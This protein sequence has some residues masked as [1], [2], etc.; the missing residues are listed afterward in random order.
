MT[1]YQSALTTLIGEVLADPELAHQDVFRRM[2]QAGLQ[3]LVNANTVELDDSYGVDSGC[4]GLWPVAVLFTFD[5]P[6]GVFAFDDAG[7]GSR[8]S[9][10][11]QSAGQ[12]GDRVLPE[13]GEDGVAVRVRRGERRPV[14]RSSGVRPAGLR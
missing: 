3:D 1:Q 11:E 8:S 6:A 10:R 12:L 9:L 7:V 2:L 5:V 13:P 4:V 14:G